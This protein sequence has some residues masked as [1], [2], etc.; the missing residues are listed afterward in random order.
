VDVSGTNIDLTTSLRGYAEKKIGTALEKHRG[1]VMSC[2]AHLTVTKNAAVKDAQVVEVTIRVKG[3]TVVR[4]EDSAPDMYAAIDS[5]EDR[6]ARKL[7]KVKDRRVIGRKQRDRLGDHAGEEEAEE[8]DDDDEEEDTYASSL[9]GVSPENLGVFAEAPMD[10]TVKKV[11]KFK[12]DAIS[13][14]EAAMCLDY[15][16]HPFYVF[17]NQATGSVSVVYKRNEGDGVGLIEPDE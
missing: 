14:A 6:I 9:G 8:E 13:V 4:A 16:D 2:E 12:M 17:R 5:V 3:G 1:R 11:K 7:R 15:I 10:M